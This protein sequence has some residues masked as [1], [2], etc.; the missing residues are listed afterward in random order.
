MFASLAFEKKIVRL[1]SLLYYISKFRLLM[2]HDFT[3]NFTVRVCGAGV[4]GWVNESGD[5]ESVKMGPSFL[6][7]HRLIGTHGPPVYHL[8]K[9]DGLIAASFMERGSTHHLITPQR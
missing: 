6:Y 3:G 9:V 8:G 7:Y 2:C 4:C 1:K 5:V